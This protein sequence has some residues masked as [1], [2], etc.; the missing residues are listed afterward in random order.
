MGFWRNPEVKKGMLLSL[1]FTVVLSIIGFILHITAGVMTLVTC[2]LFSSFHLLITYRRYRRLA[3]YSQEIDGILHG[4]DSLHLDSYAEGE[5][6]VL[7][8]EITKMTIRLR[9]QADALRKDK[10]FLADSITD[11]SHQLRTPLTSIHLLTTMLGQSDLPDAQRR[12]LVADL[13]V[14]LTRIDWLIDALL[15]MSKLDAG[16]AHLQCQPISASEL[17][18]KAFTPLA[19][20]FE[21][22]E[23]TLKTEAA[24]GESIE[25]DPDWT[26]EALGNILKNCMEHTPPGGEIAVRV[27]ENTLFTEFAV[28]DAGPGI[29]RE[30]LPHLFERFYR[31][32][33]A[34]ESSVGVGLALARMIVVSQNGTIKAENTS[35]GARFIIRFYKGVI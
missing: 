14:Q 23:L 28:T 21:L 17:I 34:G 1:L 19:I 3:G 26:A 4:V 5:L 31:G 25:C 9:E 35:S 12:S 7:H 33:G 6:D 13:K 24:G 29:D 15:K 27:C 20:P 10:V 32:K 16:T 30:D 8:S 18:Q 22:R 11:I 2:L